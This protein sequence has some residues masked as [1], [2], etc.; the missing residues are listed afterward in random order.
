MKKS[1]L[2]KKLIQFV[3]FIVLFFSVLHWSP[4]VMYRIVSPSMQPVIKVNDVVI[5]SRWI[6]QSSIEVG[7]II[8]F[9]TTLLD[10]REVIVVHYVHEILDEDS[11]L[12][13]K[14][15]AHGQTEPDRWV[16]AA[17]DVVGLYTNKITGIG[18]LLEFFSSTFGQVVLLINVGIIFAWMY[19]DDKSQKKKDEKK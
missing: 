12:S 16:I 17:D 9:H 7:D 1:K 11:V 14:T 4:F 2:Y 10:Q 13:F 8:A 19:V 6:D 15:I 5:I 18:R 3:A